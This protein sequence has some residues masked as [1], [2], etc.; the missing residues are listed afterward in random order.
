MKN[1]TLSLSTVME[2]KDMEKVHH[3]I[4]SGQVIR[5]NKRKVD[6]ERGLTVEMVNC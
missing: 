5:I 1:Q 2:I 4:K 6:Q 3:L